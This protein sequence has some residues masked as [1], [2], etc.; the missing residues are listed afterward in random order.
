MVR[1]RKATREGKEEE[2][3]EGK[4]KEEFVQK[5]GTENEK[6]TNDF[7]KSYRLSFLYLKFIINTLKIYTNTKQ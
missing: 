5:I 4:E 7:H 1:Q 6:S 3:A 2:E